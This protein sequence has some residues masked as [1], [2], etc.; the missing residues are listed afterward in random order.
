MQSLSYRKSCFVALVLACA[1]APAQAL[2]TF[3]TQVS[4]VNC[5]IT[6]SSGTTVFSDCTAL[7]FEA[8]VLPGQTA[9]VRGTFS[10]HYT[11]DGLP[12][13]PTLLPTPFGVAATEPATFEAGV[14]L[15]HYNCEQG[16]ARF[17]SMTVPPGV[18][19]SLSATPALPSMLILGLNQQSDDISGSFD[20]AVKVNLEPAGVLSYST[21]LFFRADVFAL[22]APVPE[23]AT[24]GLMAAGL[25]LGTALRRRRKT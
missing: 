25:L 4:G 15:F 3:E 5:G 7:S 16:A 24:I 11:D 8:T 19:F 1:A 14:I 6:D 9:F 13:T 21:T 12:I 18:F 23:P 22:S 10:Y 20:V 17:C 2:A